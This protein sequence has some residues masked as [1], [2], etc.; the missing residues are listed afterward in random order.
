[1]TAL[2]FRTRLTDPAPLLADGAMG[3][4][5]HATGLGMDENFER[6]N[7]TRPDL[8]EGVHARYLAAGAD[9]IETNTFGANR[10]KLAECGL[11]DQVAAVNRAG[12]EIAR[13]AAADRPAFVVGSVGPLGVGLQPFGRLKADDARAAFDEQIAALAA[14][15]IDALLCETFT[16]LAEIQIALAAARAIA[17]D[18]PVLCEMTFTADDRTLTGYLP[19]RVAHDLYTAGADVIGVNCSGG[20]AQ[21]ARV[22]YAMKQA[23]PAARFSAMPNAGFPETH[24]GR[25]MY[26]ATSDYFADYALAFRQIGASVIG[27]CCGTT[28][29][30]IAAMRAALDDPTRTTGRGGL[31]IHDPADDEDDAAPTTHMTELAA[32]L[33]AGQFV[34]TVEMT[35]PRSTAFDKLLKAAHLLRDAGADVVNIPDSPTARMRVSPWAVCQQVQA[36]VGIETILHFPTRGRNLLRVQGDLLGAHALGL[37]NIFVCMGDPTRI[38]DYPDAM[39]NFDIPPTGLIRLITD[40]L[41]GGHDQAGN[42]IGQPTGFTVGCALNLCA[43]DADKEIELLRKKLDAGANFALAQPAFDADTVERFLRRYEALEG[44]ALRLPVLMGVMPLYSLK[45]ATFLNNEIPGISIPQAILDRIDRAG[46]NAPGE[47]VTIA[48]ELLTAM[49]GMVQG[50]YIIPAYG[51]YELAAQL[52]DGIVVSA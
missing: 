6:L 9:V 1:M 47:G 50:A 18:L 49:R 13:R 15:G 36:H 5:L 39:D 23:E 11:E 7:L 27:G 52:V 32:K 44:H 35:P 19:G 12:V 45:H 2:S 37:R 31:Y 26:P 41:N 30:H 17:P 21:I 20:P 46:D 10:Y 29:E 33:A 40:R 48:R 43:D 16:D 3:T 42:S 8:I 4:L 38:G 34:V 22:L 51:R 14:A 24:G 25:T 28:P